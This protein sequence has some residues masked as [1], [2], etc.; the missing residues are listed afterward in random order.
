MSMNDAQ[1]N[2]RYDMARYFDIG[3]TIC[4]SLQ[5]I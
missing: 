3:K 2:K 5:L 4:V 1:P